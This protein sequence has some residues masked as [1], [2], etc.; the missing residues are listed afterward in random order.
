MFRANQSSGVSNG[1]STPCSIGFK[2]ARSAGVEGNIG[3]IVAEEGEPTGVDVS[4][5]TDD[6]LE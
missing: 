3:D 2:S 5:E 1:I 4:I 6:E